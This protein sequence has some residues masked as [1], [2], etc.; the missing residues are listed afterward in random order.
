[1]SSKSWARYE[2]YPSF[3]LGFHGCDR[4][5]GEAILSGKE[6]NLRKSQNDYDWLGNGIYFWESSPK[7][8]LEFAIENTKGRKSSQG[9]ISHPFVIGAVIDPKHCLNLMDRKALIEIKAAHSAYIRFFKKMKFVLP[10]NKPNGEHKLDCAVFEV[11][12]GLRR[13]HKPPLLSYDTVRG[14]FF[15]GPELYPGTNI[16]SKDHIQIC[17]RNRSCILGYF[18]PIAGN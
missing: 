10:E 6:K 1:M 8:A 7:R 11:L 4:K 5:V 13:E 2:S 15:E 9:K 3:I 16:K 12:H 17:V 18:R 14:L